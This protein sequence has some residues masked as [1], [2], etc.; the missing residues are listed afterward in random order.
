MIPNGFSNKDWEKSIVH[1]YFS[2]ILET[3]FLVVNGHS[4]SFSTFGKAVARL[5]EVAPNLLKL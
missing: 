3:Y 2:P 5:Q 4:E 1:L